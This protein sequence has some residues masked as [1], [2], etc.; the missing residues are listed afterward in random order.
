MI[1]FK[2]GTVGNEPLVI[3]C[4]IEFDKLRDL[5]AR[6]YLPQYLIVSANN[7]FYNPLRNNLNENRLSNHI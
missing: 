2:L 3:K 1:N 5:N 4:K 6:K 7:Y